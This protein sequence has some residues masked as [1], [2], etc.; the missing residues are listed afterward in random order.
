M[1]KETDVIFR[2][3]GGHVV[4]IRVKGDPDSAYAGKKL[5]VTKPE[6]YNALLTAQRRAEGMTAAIKDA[7]TGKVHVAKKDGT[8]GS[9]REV[10]Y[11]DETT[12]Q[13]FVDPSGKFYTREEAERYAGAD[14]TFRMMSAAD[15][16]NLPKKPKGLR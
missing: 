4:P 15:P 13:G 2:W 16:G 6:G 9:I 10:W 11:R 8:H 14:E 7:K 3:I 5:D 12:V 1:L